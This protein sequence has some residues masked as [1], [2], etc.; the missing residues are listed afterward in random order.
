MKKILLS[1]LF[2]A[3]ILSLGSAKAQLR[4]GSHSIKTEEIPSRLE[5]L[6]TMQLANKWFM[7]KYQD[8]T[9]PTFVNKERSSNLWTRS[10]YY[11]GLMA[12]YSICPKQ[13]YYDYTLTWCDFHKW[14]PRNGVAITNADDYCCSQTYIDMY[15][16]CPEPYKLT[17]TIALLNSYCNKP[18]LSDWWWI[19]A[20]QM[21]M[22]VFAKLGNTLGEEKYWDKMYDMYLYTRNTFDGGLW[23]ERDG[24][25]WRDYDFNPPYRTSHNRQCYWSRGNGWVVAA[26]VR[27]LVNS[28]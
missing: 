6:E 26:L 17:N 4:R 7:D 21:A 14:T 24:L 3:S 19:D 12:L 9:K 10:V 8:P 25:W 16:L 18:D 27:T 15:R 11:E 1:F 5:I 28:N 23:N 22:P 13:E 20:I 2:I